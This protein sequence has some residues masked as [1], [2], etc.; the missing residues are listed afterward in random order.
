MNPPSPGLGSKRVY[1]RKV[2]AIQTVCLLAQTYLIVDD[3]NT[4][5]GLVAL[6]E[7]EGGFQL[8]CQQIGAK[9]NTFRNQNC[10][11]IVK[12]SNNFDMAWNN[13]YMVICK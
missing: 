12:I 1:F 9:F 4:K 13:V 7:Q 2:V 6:L 11:K 8:A 10:D 3:V 5:N